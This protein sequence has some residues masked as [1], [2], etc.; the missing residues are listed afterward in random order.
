MKFRKGP[1]IIGGLA[2]YSFTTYGFYLY[3]SLTR[4]ADT[5]HNE[6]LPEDISD[7]YDKNA[8]MFDD[9]VGLVEMFMGINWLRRRL[10]RKAS[11]HVLEVSVGTGRNTA[12]YDLKRCKSLTL[13]D[14]SPVMMEIARSKFLGRPLGC[15]LDICT[16]TTVDQI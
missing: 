2:V 3:T 6:G 9:Q 4:E 15:C 10:A 8:P 7:R 13:L 14:Q 11:G 12:Y 1:W 16:L 5:F